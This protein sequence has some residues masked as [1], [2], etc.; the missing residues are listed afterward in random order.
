MKILKQIFFLFCFSLLIVSQI[1]AQT[2]NIVTSK[3]QLAQ[4]YERMGELER[5]KSIYFEVLSQQPWNSTVISAI[6][7]IYLSTKDYDS[8]VNFLNERLKNNPKDLNVY[9]ML[10]STYFIKGTPDSAKIIWQKGIE[11]K[12]EN[13]VSYRLI[14]NYAIQI[15]AFDEAID[16]LSEGKKISKNR[17]NISLEIANLLLATMDYSEAVFEYAEVLQNNPQQFQNIKNRITPFLSNQGAI[18]E[19][20]DGFKEYLSKN[21]DDTVKQFLAYLYSYKRD[22]DKAFE[23]IADLDEKTGSR[24]QLIYGFAE[25]AIKEN[26]F[27]SA[28]RAYKYL[29]DNFPESKLSANFKLGY[30][31]TSEK[32]LHDRYRSGENWKPFKTN[33]TTNSYKFTEV[34]RNYTEL[35]NEKRNI[36]ILVEAYYRKA[37]LEKNVFNNFDSAYHSFAQVVELFPNSDLGSNTYVQLGHIEVLRNNLESA[38][39]YYATAR[40]SKGASARTRSDAAFGLAKLDFWKGNFDASVSTLKSISTNTRDETTNDAIE[41]SIL[42][43]TFKNDSLSLLALAGADKLMTQKQIYMAISEFEK[44]AGTSEFFLMRETALMNLA[45][46]FVA[47]DEYNRADEILSQIFDIEK[48][49]VFSDQALYLRGNIAYYGLKDNE[50]AL[51][52]YNKLLE[53]FPNSLYFAECREK[54]NT[55]LENKTQKES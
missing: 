32:I 16:I 20:I 30:A 53:S 5:A 17:A 14:A 27:V 2:D 18:D 33:D 7:E 24:G 3:I 26:D 45:K 23:I 38:R 11:T 52:H 39:K 13:E 35:T 15:R 21:N 51:T 4:T 47:I 43:T 46:L 44:I 25:E 55:I 9:G 1:E 41:L 54:I 42:I 49:I 8:S 50:T 12:P 37:L 19:I 40:S 10:G 48:S 34:L 29:V 36:Q 6:N 28:N 31:K 22:Y